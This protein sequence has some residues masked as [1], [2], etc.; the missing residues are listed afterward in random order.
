MRV[1]LFSFNLAAMAA[2]TVPAVMIFD[3]ATRAHDLSPL[4]GQTF[5]GLLGVG[6]VLCLSA[7]AALTKRRRPEPELAARLLTAGGLVLVG[8]ISWA[9]AVFEAS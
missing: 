5:F 8:A 4:T 2:A 3:T 6:A 7:A 9:V 1:A